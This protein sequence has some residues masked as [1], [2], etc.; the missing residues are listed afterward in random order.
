VFGSF[1]AHVLYLGGT[2]SGQTAKLFNNVL[3]AM[4][5]ASIADIVEL[6]A[7]FG[8]LDPVTLVD[9]LKLGRA[10]PAPRSPCRIR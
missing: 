10:P 8:M 4:N 9:A 7:S 2:G 3:L 5:Q 1:S 6:A